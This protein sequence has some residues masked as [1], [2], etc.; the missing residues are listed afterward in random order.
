M[1][2]VHYVYF[3]SNEI[4]QEKLTILAIAGS[5]LKRSYARKKWARTQFTY[6]EDKLLLCNHVNLAGHFVPT[7]PPQK[8]IVKSYPLVFQVWGKNKRKQ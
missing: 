1:T 8:T 5:A 6:L 2:V 7:I 3:C 4:T